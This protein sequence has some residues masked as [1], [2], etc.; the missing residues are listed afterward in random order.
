[1]LKDRF[2]CKLSNWY[3]LV[4]FGFLG[5]LCKN[6]FCI[7]VLLFWYLF[8]VM[9]YKQRNNIETGFPAVML[10][11]KRLVTLK[12]LFINI[13]LTFPIHNRYYTNLLNRNQNNR[14][15]VVFLASDLLNYRYCRLFFLYNKSPSPFYREPKLKKEIF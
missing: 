6:W 11:L 2:H 10:K 13:I 3:D 15:I 1:M 5:V 9:I 14:D 12:W 8:F 7:C 4:W